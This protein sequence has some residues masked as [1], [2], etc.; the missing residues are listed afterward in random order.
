MWQQIGITALVV[1]LPG[2]LA[3]QIPL[4]LETTSSH[5]GNRNNGFSITNKDSFLDEVVAKMTVE[6]LALQLHLMFAGDIISPE[7]DDGIWNSTMSSSPDSPIGLMHDWYPM[8][9]SDYNALQRGNLE[10]SRL[11]IPLMQTGECLHGVGSF[12]QS[13]FPQ[14]IGL[15][16]S[17]DTDL[18]YRVGRAIA[19][20]ARSIG[21]HACF[22]PVLD[23]GL[24]PRWG[25]MQEAWGEDKVLTSH[26]GVAYSSG[27]SKNGSLSEPDA[28]V[29]IMKHFAAHGSPQSG[30]NAAP[31]MGHGNRQIMQD[32]MVPFKAAIDLGGVRGIMMAYN[33][34][35]DIPASVHPMLYQ[36]LEDWG[37]DGFVM[38][39]DTGAFHLCFEV[40]L[41][42]AEWTTNVVIGIMQLETVHQVAESPMDAIKQWFNVGGM[43]QFYDYPLDIYVNATRKLIDNGSVAL[44]TIKSHVRTILSVKWD[45]GLFNDPYLP[46]D[47][48]P[49]AIARSNHDLTLEA[50][51]K[52]I[53]LLENKNT[54]LPLNPD[55]QNIKTIALIGPF[56][57]TLNYG[58]YSGT[59]GQAPADAAK[60]LREALLGYASKSN[61]ELELVSSWGANAWEYNSQYAVPGY[62]LSS[63]GAK[64]GL[65][66]SY[67]ATTDFREQLVEKLETPALDWGLYP[68][69]GLPSTNFS[70]IWEGELQS[71]VDL[72]V[73]GWLGVAVGPN[74]TVRLFV[75][76]DL[77]MTQGTDGPSS[78]GTIM[79]NIMDY[80]YIQ[81]NTTSP[82]PGAA[83]FT[84]RPGDTY[85]IR[86]EY[87][88]FNLYKKIA[89]VVSLN[90]QMVLFWNLASRHGDAVE[91]ATQ[92]ASGS[93]LIVLA[94]GAAWNSDGENGD[95]AALGL[96]AS[97]DI[98]AREMYRLR[99]PV[100]LV[101]QG[102]R[103]F[104]I[105]EYYDESAAVISTFF[106]GQSGGQAIA[107]ALFGATNPGG[108][109]PVT[110]PKHVGQLPVYYNYKSLA[111]KIPYLDADSTPSYPFGYGLSYTSFE[112]TQFAT[113]SGSFTEGD[114]ITFSATVKNTGAM[115]GSHVLQ[116]VKQ[117]VT[118]KRMYLEAEEEITVLLQLDAD[119]YLTI[120]N[121][122]NEWELEKGQYTFAL[123][124]HGGGTADTSLN[125]TM[126]CI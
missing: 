101:L 18:V 60:T 119:R 64:G 122:S 19:T 80:S 1:L 121:R 124:A 102:G 31:F 42:K 100:V 103:P 20:E 56:A 111:R 83:P 81:T 37:Y 36:A 2:A 65:S 95:R 118:F 79:S 109:L 63:R 38:A 11:K 23:L 115:A 10:R 13:L 53:V 47:T 94:V 78:S 113:S 117:L 5:D 84:F 14:S 112:V 85:H 25:R 91:Q 44:S 92:V 26:M 110:V 76:G 62:L 125:V 35:D 33:E 49:F 99:K 77:I 9:A 15:S 17:F 123:L 21:V 72:D 6:D 55:E 46:L 51:G 4:H 71:P 107:D 24:D 68:P 7:L 54:T 75:D 108:R 87:Q 48:D 93:D 116:P 82:P 39:D 66:A 120:L 3:S 28:V 104:A 88:A 8:N 12:K 61:T 73:D 69:A 22:S 89:N 30:H 67:F 70:V 57:D 59:W 52:S 114:T 34:L 90:H 32:L 41:G 98:L 50:A 43:L 96:S 58:G 27:L 97:Q 16:A 45:L 86:I 74:T 29:P 40:V 126:Q 106:P 105:P